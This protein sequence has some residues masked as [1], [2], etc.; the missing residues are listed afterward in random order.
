METINDTPQVSDKLKNVITTILGIMLIC[1]TFASQFFTSLNPWI[2]TIGY[3]M[4]IILIYLKN[5]QAIELTKTIINKGLDK[6]Q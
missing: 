6:L 3:A 5:T 1:A 2:Y 4:G